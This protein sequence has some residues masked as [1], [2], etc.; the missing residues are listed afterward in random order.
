[1]SS[2]FCISIKDIFYTFHKLPIDRYRVD[3]HFYDISSFFSEQESFS[4]WKAFKTVTVK[5]PSTINL[6][7]HLMK[8]SRV[9]AAMLLL[10]VIVMVTLYNKPWD[11][12]K[13]WLQPHVLGGDDRDHLS[14]WLPQGAHCPPCR[15]STIEAA[16]GGST[17]YHRRLCKIYGI[18]SSGF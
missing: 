12:L 6:N 18:S 3:F 2:L 1:M 9:I 4:T 11:S 16:T 17:R 13:I 15:W 8:A 14:P 5:V 7:H 10:M